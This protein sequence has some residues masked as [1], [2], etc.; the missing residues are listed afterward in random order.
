MNKNIACH[1]CLVGC[2]VKTVLINPITSAIQLLFTFS[3]NENVSLLLLLLSVD[4]KCNFV[5]FN[6]GVYFSAVKHGM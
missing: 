1:C 2:V 3:A 4:E 5:E 6:D